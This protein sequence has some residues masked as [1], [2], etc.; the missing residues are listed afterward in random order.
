MNRSHVCEARDVAI[1]ISI[2]EKLKSSPIHSLLATDEL[3]QRRRSF[4]VRWQ[5]ANTLRV[6]TENHVI[7]YLAQEAGIGGHH[8]VGQ[9]TR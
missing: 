7:R 8:V 6:S 9:A 1:Y 4:C 5:I 2:H 3:E